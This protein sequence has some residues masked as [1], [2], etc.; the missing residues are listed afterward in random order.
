M[1][2]PSPS[3]KEKRSKFVSR[4][5][6]DLTRKGEGKD[7]AQRVAICNSRFKK[8]KATQIQFSLGELEA[9]TNLIDST[10]GKEEKK[11]KKK[12]K[13]DDGVSY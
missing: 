8:S 3:G 10:S 5:V 12:K 13:K 6:S 2:L 7:A 1:P 4:C 9:L 11:K